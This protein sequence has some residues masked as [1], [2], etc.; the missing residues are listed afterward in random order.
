MANGR[1]SPGLNPDQARNSVRYDLRPKILLVFCRLL[2]FFKINFFE[3]F[4]QEY[5][6]NVKKFRTFTVILQLLYVF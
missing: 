3:K 4:F 1:V 2:I 6:P 5:N